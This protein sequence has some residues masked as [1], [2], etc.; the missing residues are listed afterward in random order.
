MLYKLVYSKKTD[1]KIC[2]KFFNCKD[3]LQLKNETDKFCSLICLY[4]DEILEL[5]EVV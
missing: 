3:L 1:N 2:N 4:R 5:K